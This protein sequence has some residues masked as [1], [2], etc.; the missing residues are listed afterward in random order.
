VE[1]GYAGTTTLEPSAS[2]PVQL[3]VPASVSMAISTHRA[4]WG[5]KIRLS[6]R[7]NGGHVPRSGELVVLW[8]GWHGGFTEIGHLYTGSD[9]RFGST[10]TFLRG[11][12]TETY[13]LWATT[14]SESDYP[15]APASSRKSTITVS[16]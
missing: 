16:G 8:I 5:G 1:A 3:V 9:G 14:A 6:G 11:N 7:L 10:Y 12:G 13:R 4:R 15:Y 2:A